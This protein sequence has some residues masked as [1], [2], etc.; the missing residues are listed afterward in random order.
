[1]ISKAIESDKEQIADI[2]ARTEMFSQE[3]IDTVP[4]LFD[5]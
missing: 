3:E 2:T 5:E 4:I 1:M